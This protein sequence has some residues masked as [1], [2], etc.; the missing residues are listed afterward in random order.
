[1]DVQSV[2]AINMMAFSAVLALATLFNRPNASWSFLL[3]NLF[4]IAV[5][6]LALLRSPEISGFLVALP[7]LPLVAAPTLLSILHARAMRLGR[8]D[9]AARY[10]RWA[11]WLHPSVNARRSAA[12]ARA[13]AI[14][15]PGARGAA[16]RAVER[17]APP[18]EAAFLEARRLVERRDWSALLEFSARADSPLGP[19]IYVLRALGEQNRID[20]LM[21]AYA[22]IK[23]R[24]PIDQTTTAWLFVL[25]FGGRPE[26]VDLL[27]SRTLRLEAGAAAYWRAVAR[28]YAGDVEDA[29]RQLE[30]IAAG[31]ANAQAAP[32]ARQR[33][34]EEWAA[35]PR[36]APDARATVDGVARRVEVENGR[37]ARDWRRLRATFALVAANAAMFAVE[38]YAGG[39]ED[40]DTLVSLGALAAPLALQGHEYWRLL[41][42]AF[43][44]FGALHFGLNMLMLSIVCR[45]VEA[46]LGSA[47]AFLVYVLGALAS[48]A[49]V[50]ATMSGEHARYGIYVG[51]S[52]AIFALFGVVCVL[53]FR[54][55]RAEGIRLDVLRVWA[56]GLVILLQIGADF[57]LPMSSMA[58]HLSGFAFGLVAGVA[59]VATRRDASR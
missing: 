9:A 29:R 14:D 13:N 55:W 26:T 7:F 18:R 24:I 37:R 45:D 49:F 3:V 21:R 40:L 10:A 34:E 5:G 33:L 8:R 59:L 38:I 44:H 12:L 54:D 19:N 53:R 28:Q 27:L 42:A 58:G 30:R 11:A 23:K 25:A 35:P 56:L 39:A 46:V 22:Q 48:S 4:V 47:R 43:L 17:D 50:L 57:V 41:T 51:A 32:A 36:L 6:V 31:D 2:L 15:D 20:E 16:L 1:M 52:G